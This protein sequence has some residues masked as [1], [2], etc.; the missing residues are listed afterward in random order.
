MITQ[1]LEENHSTP[2]LHPATITV[3]TSTLFFLRRCST[4]TKLGFAKP[5]IYF[6]KEGK[7]EK[8]RKK[9]KSLGHKP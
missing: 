3:G 7:E 6:K 2:D 1:A 5:D 4:S 8:K 9:E